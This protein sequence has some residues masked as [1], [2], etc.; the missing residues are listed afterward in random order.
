[1]SDNEQFSINSNDRAKSVHLDL[2]QVA[3]Y[4]CVKLLNINFVLSFKQNPILNVYHF[5]MLQVDQAVIC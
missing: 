3:H 4:F 2:A 1:M 5:P